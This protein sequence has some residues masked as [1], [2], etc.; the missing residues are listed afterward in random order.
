M[1]KSEDWKNIFTM[2]WVNIQEI[3][4]IFFISLIYRQFILR[5]RVDRAEKN[6]SPYVRASNHESRIKSSH[7]KFL[8]KK[9]SDLIFIDRHKCES[10]SIYE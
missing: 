3:Q 1:P 2:L 7:C 9:S 4:D 8:T 6:K 5:R 10:T